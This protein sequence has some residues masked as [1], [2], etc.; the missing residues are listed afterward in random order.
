V[1]EDRFWQGVAAFNGQQFYQCHD[2]LEAIWMESTESEKNFYQGILQIAVACYHLGNGNWRG[3]VILLGEGIRRLADFQ[4]IYQD[5]DVSQLRQD[6]Y[7]LLAELQPMS[8]QQFAKFVQRLSAQDC[9]PSLT[10]SQKTENP[11][12]VNS[13]PGLLPKIVKIKA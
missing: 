8:A 9:A 7:V 2:L 5:I 1:A 13:F 11:E 3:T 10:E 4:P 12:R 6:S